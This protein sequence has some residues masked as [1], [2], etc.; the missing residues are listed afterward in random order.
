MKAQVAIEYLIIASIG[1][2]LVLIGGKYLL[3]VFLDYSDQN[4]ISIAKN[5]VKKLGETADFVSSQ[6]PPSKTKIRILIPDGVQKI[7]FEN[8]T[9]VL[10]LKTRSG[11]NDIYYKT[12]TEIRGNLPL[13]SSEYYIS[14]ES[15][16]NY[17]SISVVG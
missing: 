3:D 11:I 9:I 1:L 12:K 6:G 16:E 10:S 17:V 4:R 2:I 7:S 5:T 13:K 15:K 8:K 14:L